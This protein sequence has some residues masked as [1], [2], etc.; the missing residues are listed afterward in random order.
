MLLPHRMKE[1]WGGRK[2]IRG[3]RFLMFLI[4]KNIHSRKT[5]IFMCALCG[6][7]S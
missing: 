4:F 6:L 2:R 7:A 3:G 5:V 1:G